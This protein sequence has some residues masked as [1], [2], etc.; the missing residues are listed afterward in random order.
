MFPCIFTVLDS[1]KQRSLERHKERQYNKAPEHK[2]EVEHQAVPAVRFIENKF[3]S[4]SSGKVDGRCHREHGNRND[5]RSP[6]CER[7]PQF[8]QFDTDSSGKVLHGAPSTGTETGAI[9]WSLVSSRNMSSSDAWT[10]LISYSLSP[11]RT[12]TAARSGT[13]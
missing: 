12:S 6:Q 5:P 3:C 7:P 1:C 9:L 4:I 10:A 2:R 8:E 13:F 11:A